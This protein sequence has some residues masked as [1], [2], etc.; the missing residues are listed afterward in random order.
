[1]KNAAKKKSYFRRW[2]GFKIF[3]FTSPFL[4]LVFLFAYLPLFGWVHAFYDYH[5]RFRM[6]QA[7]FVGLQWFTLMFSTASWRRM[8]AEILVN[9]FAMSFIGILTS[10]L[11]MVF[12][13]LLNEI[14]NVKYRRV[15][16]TLTTIPNFISWVLVYS[17]AFSLFSS[18]GLINDLLIQFGIISRPIMFLHM[19]NGDHAWAAMWGLG[20]WKTLGWSAIIYMAAIAG[21]DQ[22][23]Y[24]AARVDGANRFRTIWHITIPGLI[25]TYM[26]LLLLS[27]AHFL[28]SGIE[29]TY[30]FQNAFN[31]R[32]IQTLDLYVF[33]LGIGSASYSLATAIGM[34]KSFV[35]LVLLFTVNYISKLVRGESII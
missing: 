5:P 28:N 11:P 23:L 7:P 9:T 2:E 1:M 26:V 30:V 6:F 31:L 4:L 29:S 20:T 25:P 12:A 17:L 19:G 35:S 15:V 27:I 24:E 18:S 14:R 22:E 3:L 33:N 32:R 10:W 13:I 34:M 16:Q 8:L 21:I